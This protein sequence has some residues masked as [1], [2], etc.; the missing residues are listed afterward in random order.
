MHMMMVQIGIYPFYCP[1]GQMVAEDG[2]VSFGGGQNVGQSQWLRLCLCMFTLLPQAPHT[3]PASNATKSTLRI[4]FF[5]CVTTQFSG[6][7]K[8]IT[9]LITHNLRL[10]CA[11]VALV[12]SG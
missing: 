2:T 9:I 6:L 3:V 1:F 4:V 12:F 8:Q 10:Y 5:I 11:L 7:T